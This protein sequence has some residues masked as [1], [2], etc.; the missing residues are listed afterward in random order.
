MEVDIPITGV[1]KEEIENVDYIIRCT[2]PHP[3]IKNQNFKTENYQK[4]NSINFVVKW[5]GFKSEAKVICAQCR[6]ELFTHNLNIQTIGGDKDGLANNP[7]D[8]DNN[9][10]NNTSSGNNLGDTDNKETNKNS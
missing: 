10:G 1:K 4:C 5:N 8:N 6:N 3:R 9:N 7:S 2:H